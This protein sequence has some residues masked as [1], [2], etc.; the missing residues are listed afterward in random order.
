MEIK[1]KSALLC[2]AIALTGAYM[3][4]CKKDEP[5]KPASKNETTQITAEDYNAGKRVFEESISSTANIEFF[6]LGNEVMVSVGGH[7]D[8]DSE[9]MTKVKSALQERTLADIYSKVMA[10]SGNSRV[11]VPQ[12]L[13]DL[14]EKYST[15]EADTLNPEFS[16]N[17]EGGDSFEGSANSRI[18]YTVDANWFKN[19]VYQKSPSTNEQSHI[20]T[21][22]T[23]AWASRKGYYHVAFGMAASETAKAR[24]RGWWESCVLWSCSWKSHFDVTIQP[25]YWKS[26][27]WRGSESRRHRKFRVDGLSPDKRIH[28]GLTWSEDRASTSSGSTSS[29]DIAAY[30]SSFS[31]NNL[32]WYVK[33]TGSTTIYNPWIRFTYYGVPPYGDT[34]V[35]EW[36]IFA[37]LA[38]GQTYGDT[39]Y[40]NASSAKILIDSK[41]LIRESNEVN[42]QTSR[43]NSPR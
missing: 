37:T 13:L 5:V 27:S 33:N 14:D 28:F 16:E 36:Q 31:Y 40:A 29:A 11:A 35:D 22:Y 23:Y 8:E 42:N 19:L 17:G 3:L 32:K 9:V 24:F 6:D 38:P 2:A 10:S 7:I 12:I 21:N 25:R 1:F 43:S 15:S 30:I 41:G 4:S 18:D 39:R 26:Y 34:K 20:R